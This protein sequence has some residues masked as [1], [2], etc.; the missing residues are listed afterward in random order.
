MA[1]PGEFPFTIPELPT[2]ATPVLLL[3]HVPPVV[4]LAR[5]CTE[6][7]HIENVPVIADGTG[8]TDISYVAIHP[9]NVYVIVVEPAETPVVTP[10]EAF[11]VATEV[12]PDVQLPPVVALLNVTALP[13]HTLLL[14]V[15]DE[16]SGLTVI[17]LEE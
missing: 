4:E 5:V 17:C 11:I 16:G 10:V 2:V 13:T 8:F 1:V 6:P 7:L 9:L 12:L 3:D 15:I 14:P